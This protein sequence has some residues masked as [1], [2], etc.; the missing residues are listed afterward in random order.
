MSRNQRDPSVDTLELF[1]RPNEGVPS[2]SGQVGELRSPGVSDDPR[3]MALLGRDSADAM[4]EGE[5][6]WAMLPPRD[7]T[8]RTES[9]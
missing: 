6:P 4:A 8:E 3:P 2:D 7:R 5:L 9:P 1:P